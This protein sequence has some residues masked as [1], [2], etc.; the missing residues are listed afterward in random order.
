[1]SAT[2]YETR[3]ARTYVRVKTRVD[4]STLAMPDIATRP[5]INNFYFDHCGHSRGEVDVAEISQWYDQL[6]WRWEP[7]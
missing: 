5:Q 1:M 3:V 6:G 2:A 7:T 4:A